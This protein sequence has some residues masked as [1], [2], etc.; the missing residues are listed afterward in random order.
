MIQGTTHVTALQILAA[1]GIAFLVRATAAETPGAE[2]GWSA[3][4]SSTRRYARRKDTNVLEEKVPKYTL[5]DPLTMASGEK[6]ADADAWRRTRRPEILTLF[7]KHVYGIAPGR[8]K[9]MTFDVFDTDAKAL[10]GKAK[11]KQITVRF[12]GDADGPSMDILLYLPAAVTGPTP[13]FVALNFQG[14]HSIHADKGIRLSTRWMRPKGKGVVNNRATEASRAAA[15]SRWV[16]EKILARGYALATIY[17]GDVD[18]DY[19]DGFKNGVHAAFDKSSR[20]GDAWGSIA[21]WAWGL[22]RAVD[23][24]ETDRDV[25]AK[26]IIVMGHSRLGKTSLWAGASDERFALVISNNSGCG[27]A[28]LN[29]RAYGETVRRINTSFPHWFCDNFKKYNDNEA[30]LPVDQHML[31]SLI[32]PRPVY[33]ASAD[34]DLWADP[35]GEFLSARGAD[36][37]YRLLG[38]SG[39]P[40]KAMPPL[41]RPVHGTIGY[42]VRSGGHGVTDFDWTQYMDFADKMLNAECPNECRMLN[43]EVACRFSIRNPKSPIRNVLRRALSRLLK[44][45]GRDDDDRLDHEL[46]VEVDVPQSEDVGQDAHE[47]RAYDGPDDPA[48]AAREAGSPDDNGGDHVQ[49]VGHPRVRAAMVLLGGVQHARDARQRPG[50][51]VDQD[52]DPLGRQPRIDGGL[53]VVAQ[54]PHVA[55]EYGP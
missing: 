13:I 14:N 33:V 15:A 44:C 30:K 5:P 18:P 9:G 41:D 24:F 49:F 36:P 8:P 46:D 51:H 53:G 29:R 4:A 45:N 20:G 42:H 31:I 27:G 7:Q 3:S 12:T 40:V 43:A 52:D 25:D 54:R 34:Q 28:A 6:V 26:R 2:K 35:R 21:A 10:G 19:H 16:V 11:R 17:Y 50:E 38:T 37:V 32:A 47:E 55:P 48:L 22:S 23:Y 39:L 1:V